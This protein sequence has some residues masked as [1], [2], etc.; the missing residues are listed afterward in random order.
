[1]KVYCCDYNQTQTIVYKSPIVD[2]EST[3]GASQTVQSVGEVFLLEQCDKL[4]NVVSTLSLH[5]H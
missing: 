5:L 2:V 4:T 3:M 1:M